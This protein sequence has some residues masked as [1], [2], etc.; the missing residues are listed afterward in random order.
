MMPW[1]LPITRRPKLL[2]VDD[3]AINI[4]L[5]HQLFREECDVF[6][7]TSGEQAIALCHNLMPDLILLDVIMAGLSGH[8]V[9][10]RLKE[11]PD[12][13]SIPI[14][15][16]TA[17]QEE[18]D[19]EYGL[20]LGAVDFISKPISPNIVRAR[21]KAHLTLKMQGDLLRNLAMLDGLTGIPNRRQ[22]DDGLALQWRQGCRDRTPLSLIMLDVDY[23]KRYNDH[24]GHQ[25]GDQCLQ[26]IAS[27]LAERVGRPHDLVARYGGEEFACILPNTPLTS[28]VHIA[29]SMCAAVRELAIEHLASDVA[30]VVTISLGVVTRI[31]T[32]ASSPQQLLEAADR[33]LYQ[34]K[35]AGR[36]RVVVDNSSE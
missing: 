11:D 10:L 7:A 18:T 28:A 30:K 25:A 15:F 23:F 34:A 12:T 36:A 14:I 33:Q 4:R 13:Q 17:Q 35:E 32:L 26:A 3:Q 1:N 24:Y 20:A 27:V 21:V 6:M 8:E 22:F 19:E 29:E 16:I 31:P 5:L 9:C 2:I